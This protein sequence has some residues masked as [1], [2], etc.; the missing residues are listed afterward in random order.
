M[1]YGGQQTCVHPGLKFVVASA[2]PISNDLESLD[3]F[4]RSVLDKRPATLDSTVLDIPWRKASHQEG[5]KLRFGFLSEDP[6]FPIHPPVKRTLENAAKALRSEGH[7]VI[8]LSPDEALVT[9]AVA[10]AGLLFGLDKTA[11]GL[12]QAAGE[13]F[14]PS[15]VA[16]QQNSARLQ[17]SPNFAKFAHLAQL[18]G[19]EKL[20]AL[21]VERAKILAAWNQLWKKHQIDAVIAP[22]TR[23]TAVEHDLMG[24]PAYTMLLNLLDV[25]SHSIFR[26]DAR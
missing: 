9:D 11:A 23:T 5:K 7:E 22:S 16:M 12:V 24:I 8:V 17:I 26:K 15:L 18:E 19:F 14:I 2:G 6:N 3:F 10:I 25:S 21:N 4:V 1:P 20:A 13:P